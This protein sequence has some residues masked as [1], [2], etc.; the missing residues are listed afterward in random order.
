[1]L[2]TRIRHILQEGRNEVRQGRQNTQ[3]GSKMYENLSSLD[4]TNIVGCVAQTASPFVPKFIQ[5]GAI[6]V[7]IIIFII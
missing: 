3:R 7:I 5:K 2:T 1:M 4:L 6:T